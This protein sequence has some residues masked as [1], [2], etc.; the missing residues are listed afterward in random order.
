[1]SRYRHLFFDACPDFA[2]RS[3]RRYDAKTLPAPDGISARSRS[4]FDRLVRDLR[5]RDWSKPGF[6]QSAWLKDLVNV[7]G[8]HYSLAN[9]SWATMTHSVRG[10]L[11]PRMVSSSG[12][13]FPNTLGR[14]ITIAFTARDAHSS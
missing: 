12:A 6:T 4:L 10:E 11:L 8:L 14:W 13:V 1:M 9:V 3:S 7:V 5:S 2:K